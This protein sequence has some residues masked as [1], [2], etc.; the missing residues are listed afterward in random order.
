MSKAG[1]EKLAGDVNIQ[2]GKTIDMYIKSSDPM[3]TAEDLEKIGINKNSIYNIY[4]YKKEDEKVLFI[5]GVFVYGFI[6]LMTL[7]YCIKYF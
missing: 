3:K 6:T 5:I 2:N 4:E 1:F 7:D